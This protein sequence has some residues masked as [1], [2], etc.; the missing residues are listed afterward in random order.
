M[1]SLNF[2]FIDITLVQILR[3]KVGQYALKIS[4]YVNPFHNQCFFFACIAAVLEF[5]CVYIA[6]LVDW[7]VYRLAH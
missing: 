5:F 4:A 7:Q 3:H 2:D 6:V 1:R